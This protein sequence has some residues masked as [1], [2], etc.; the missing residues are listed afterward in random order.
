MSWTDSLH[1]AQQAERDGR[2]DVALQAYEA[3]LASRGGAGSAAEISPIHRRI[4][5]VHAQR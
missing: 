1:E 5:I 4:G 3:A 2:W